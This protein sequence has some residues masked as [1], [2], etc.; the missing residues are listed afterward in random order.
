MKHRLLFVLPHLQ[1][2]GAERVSTALLRGLSRER[3]E[4]H[5]ALV[6]AHGDLLARVPEDVAV[7]DLAA[8]RVRRAPIPVVRLV[9]RLRPDV[10]F[11]TLAY[12]NFGLLLLRSTLPA[13]TPLV[14][15]EAV[16]AS[17]QIADYPRERVW[18]AGYRWLYPRADAIVCP[19][20]VVIDDLVRNFGCPQE[21]MRYIPNP[22]DVDA[23]RTAAASAPSPFSGPGPHLL[24]VGR[25][26]PQ[27]GFDLLI[28]AF[29]ALAASGGPLARAQ[30]WIAGE[31]AERGALAARATQR[32]LA[33]RVHLV[34]FLP[35]PYPWMRHA[36]LFVLSS[37]WEGLP[38]VVLEVLAC[39]TPVV[40]FDSP[41]GAR[42]IL[43]DVAAS[44]LVPAGDS[45]ALSDAIDTQLRDTGAAQ[46]ELPA[47]YRAEEVLSAYEQLFAGIARS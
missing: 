24:G 15:R 18:A 45:S 26:E 37:R 41:G 39:G 1:P 32:G 7:H 16:A 23:L 40:A 6:S 22:V 29:A 34:G 27:K 11:S 14:V 19:A 44:R 21:R 9:R 35:D 36:D 10:V 17:Q 38:N 31:G 46:P 2:G 13:R 28:D 43:H 20:R 47:R 33:D 3:F 8:G 5:L 4:L 30:L 25:L 12:L 42:E